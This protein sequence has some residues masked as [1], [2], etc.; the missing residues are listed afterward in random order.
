MR[1]RNKTLIGEG[2]AQI[3]P[4][5]FQDEGPFSPQGILETWV[6]WQLV[7]LP[8]LTSPLWTS[9]NWLHCIHSALGFRKSDGVWHS[10]KTTWKALVAW[11]AEGDQRAES[12]TV[13]VQINR[14]VGYVLLSVY[15]SAAIFIHAAVRA[16][17]LRRREKCM[18]WAKWE[19]CKEIGEKKINYH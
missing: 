6:L 4:G 5:I 9:I 10:V 7:C 2:R 18:S 14:V 1:G 15:I 17:Q 8:C 16:T 11:G 19:Q 3:L 12:D 13:S